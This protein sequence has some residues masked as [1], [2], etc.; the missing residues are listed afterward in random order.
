MRPA[1]PDPLALAVRGH[2]MVHGVGPVFLGAFAFRSTAAAS[3]VLRAIEVLRRV[4]AGGRRSL[5][6]R[7]A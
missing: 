1:E 2:A 5:P 7:A 6:K 3:G 4:S